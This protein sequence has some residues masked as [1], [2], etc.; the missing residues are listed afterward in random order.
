M[1]NSHSVGPVLFSSTAVLSTLAITGLTG[2]L[3]GLWSAP[4]LRPSMHKTS[5]IAGRRRKHKKRH[6][7]HHHSSKRPDDPLADPPIESSTIASSSTHLLPLDSK[8]A[9]DPVAAG[10][11]RGSD[12]SGS[13]A[14]YS[15]SGSDSEDSWDDEDSEDDGFDAA[16][17]AFAGSS[18][19]C[20]MVLVVRTDL[21]MTK[22]K[23][24]AQ[25]AHA[26]VACY[27]SISRSNPL[28]LARWERRG[29]AKVALKA[30]SEDELLT[31]QALAASLDITSKTIR[32]A[33]RTQIEA[34]SMTVLGIGPAP[35]SA[36]NQV[37]GHLKLL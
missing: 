18:E 19:D 26:A 10:G 35:I 13:D 7:H 27:K 29:Q 30:T 3:L 37:T 31:L 12:H 23:V 25:C 36:I 28:I 6:H 33:G 15:D 16:P 9:S 2:F 17:D 5:K 34:G 4:A 24:A 20:K 32:D 14:A 1:T 22:G 21:G 8:L 11:A